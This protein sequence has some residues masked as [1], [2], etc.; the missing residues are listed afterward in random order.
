MNSFKE[1]YLPE[2]VYG[3]IDGLI[4][5]FAIVSGVMGASLSAGIILILGFANVLADGLS[6]GASNYL[7]TK[8]EQDVHRKKGTKHFETSNPVRTGLVTFSS[9]VIIGIIPLLPFLFGYFT[10]TDVFTLFVYS[11]IITGITFFFVGVLRGFISGTSWLQAGF[12][13]LIIGSI[14]AGISYGVG[15]LLQGLGNF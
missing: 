4:T 8:S 2:F 13:T 12:E 14:A 3:A 10:S 9:F 15:S 7:S 5:T 11:I 1:K 6:M